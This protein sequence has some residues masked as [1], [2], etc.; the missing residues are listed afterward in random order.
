VQREQFCAQ[1]TALRTLVLAAQ[2]ATEAQAQ[3]PG[4]LL[5]HLDPA[6]APKL[7]GT[8]A[9]A[10]DLGGAGGASGKGL[11]ITTSSTRP[12][13]SDCPQLYPLTQVMK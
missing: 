13:P 1:F 8:N 3:Q 5:R 6:G 10:S 2:A 9:A 12:Q 11:A 7:D 4:A